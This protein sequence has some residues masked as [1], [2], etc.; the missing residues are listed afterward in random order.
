MSGR[1]KTKG[2]F[3]KLRSVRFV[4]KSMLSRRSVIFLTIA[5]L[6]SSFLG[7]WLIRNQVQRQLEEERA[8]LEKQ[9][10]VP[11]EKTL[12]P[13]LASKELAIW[14]SFRNS[15]GIV[16][17]KNIYFVATDGGLVEFDAAGNLHID[18]DHGKTPQEQERFPHAALEK[19]VPF[20]PVLKTEGSA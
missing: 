1:E 20:T 10:L 12:R 7:L 13:Q 4:P 16:R 17:F 15:K 6:T 3:S 8:R 11:F 18:T 14:Q 19:V 2:L 9:D 5:I